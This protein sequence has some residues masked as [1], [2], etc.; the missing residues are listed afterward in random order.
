MHS[1]ATIAHTM[2]IST[3]GIFL[4]YEFHIYNSY[5]YFACNDGGVLLAHAPAPNRDSHGSCCSGPDSNALPGYLHKYCTYG[6]S[7]LA[8]QSRTASAVFIS[9]SPTF[10]FYITVRQPSR[11]RSHTHLRSNLKQDGPDDDGFFL[12]LYSSTT[13]EA[14]W[15]TGQRR[16]SIQ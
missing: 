11:S 5:Y 10:R 7:V 2:E 6:V 8:C 9:C 14:H 4:L 12:G 3:A 1:C 15:N 13:R 16:S